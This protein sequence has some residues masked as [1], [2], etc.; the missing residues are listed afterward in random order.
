MPPRSLR[1]EHAGSAPRPRLH[2]RPTSIELLDA[3][4]GALGDDV[5]PLLEGRAAFQLRVTLRA[6][7]IVG[8]ELRDA[9]VHAAVHAAALAR[10]GVADEREL[11]AAIR[12]GEL[13]EREKDVHAVL[14][15][16]VRAKL[17][18]ANPRYLEVAS[19]GSAR[20]RA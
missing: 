20:E 12:G 19:N 18:V 1:S 5:L 13:D 17:E 9:E 15:A 3:A 10:L 2:D 11:A 6:L 8:R 4:R 7:G 16:I 14:R